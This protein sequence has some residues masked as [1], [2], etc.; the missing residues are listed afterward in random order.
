MDFFPIAATKPIEAARACS[1]DAGGKSR[2]LT[3]AAQ[4]MDGAHA[5][6]HD[7]NGKSRWCGFRVH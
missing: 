6:A 3:R 7:A 4:K 1:E 5:I 2:V